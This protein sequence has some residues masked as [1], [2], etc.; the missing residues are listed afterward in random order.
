LLLIRSGGRLS[1]F[2][3][4]CG[5]SPSP[6]LVPLHCAVERCTRYVAHRSCAQHRRVVGACGGIPRVECTS[7]HDC[8]TPPLAPPLTTRSLLWMPTTVPPGALAVR[9]TSDH[10]AGH[11]CALA[12]RSAAAVWTPAVR[13]RRHAASWPLSMTSEPGRSG[14]CLECRRAWITDPTRPDAQASWP[15]LA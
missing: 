7:A 6:A 15:C 10:R 4:D 1:R 2:R 5:R 12:P 14:S 11:P 3:P 9:C 8:S 13:G